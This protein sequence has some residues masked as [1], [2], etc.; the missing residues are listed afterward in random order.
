MQVVCGSTGLTV[1]LLG[2][3]VWKPPMAQQNTDMATAM[4]ISWLKP[5]VWGILEGE[6]VGSNPAKKLETYKFMNLL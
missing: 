3:G 6:H 1:D 4:S 2:V 5:L